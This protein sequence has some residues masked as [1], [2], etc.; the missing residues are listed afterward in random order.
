MQSTKYM[1]RL[2]FT[3]LGSGFELIGDY[4]KQIFEVL[5]INV[6]CKRVFLA[7][8]SQYDVNHIGPQY[9]YGV[10]SFDALNL[11]KDVNLLLIFCGCMDPRK[12]TSRNFAVSENPVICQNCADLAWKAFTFKSKCISTEEIILSHVVAKDVTSLDMKW[13]YYTEMA[14]EVTENDNVCR[15]CMACVG[16]GNYLC[17][18]NNYKCLPRNKLEQYLPEIFVLPVTVFHLSSDI[19]LNDGGSPS[20]NSKLQRVSNNVSDWFQPSD[21]TEGIKSSPKNATKLPAKGFFREPNPTAKRSDSASPVESM[22]HRPIF[23][24]PFYRRDT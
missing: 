17:L 4:M 14:C 24:V 13:I 16:E 23:V 10:R 3:Q 21:E 6:A 7:K 12:V 5:L 19:K 2:C 22:H 9:T 1:C 20:S 8:I 11:V 18:E 15:F